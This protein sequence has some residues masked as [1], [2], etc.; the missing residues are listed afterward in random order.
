VTILAIVLIVLCVVM[1]FKYQ[2]LKRA[3]KMM[4]AWLAE[5]GIGA[6]TEEFKK[7]YTNAIKRKYHLQVDE[8]E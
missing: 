2:I 4:A 3:L 5:N 8:K 6:P 7:H 1:S